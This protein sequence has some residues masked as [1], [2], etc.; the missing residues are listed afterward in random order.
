[1]QINPLL[2]SL[3]VYNSNASITPYNKMDQESFLDYMRQAT[4]TGSS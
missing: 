1:M 2:N 3:G 4:E